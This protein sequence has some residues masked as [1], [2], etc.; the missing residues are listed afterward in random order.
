M[1]VT[2]EID[3]AAELE[4]PEMYEE[5]SLTDP[6]PHFSGGIDSLRS[7]IRKNIKLNKDIKTFTGR[8]YVGF[9]VNINGSISDVEV[10]NGL[11]Q[12]CDRAAADIVRTMP[13]FLPFTDSSGIPIRSKMIIPIKF[14]LE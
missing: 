12:P 11:C 2:S 13:N 3:H 7:V 8:V 10:L 6:M 9:T 1:I 4:Q 5:I 14:G